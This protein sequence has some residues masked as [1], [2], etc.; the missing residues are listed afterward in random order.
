MA[1]A[2]LLVVFTDVI[3]YRIAGLYFPATF[4]SL[5]PVCR[6]RA[7][8][9]YSTRHSS[10]WLTVAFTLDRTVAICYQRLQ[11]VCCTEQTAAVIIAIV[12]L[13]LTL[14]NIPRCF[15]YEPSFTVN[16]VPWFCRT[17]PSYYTSPAWT[18][19]S[20]LQRILTPLLPFVLVLLLN[21]LTVRHIVRSSR[22]RRALR[23]GKLGERCGDDPE[24]ENRRRSIVVLFGIS[25]TFILLWSSYVM[26]F[27]YWRA[28]GSR[29]HSGPSDPLYIA[30][31]TGYM[32]LLLNCCTNTCVYAVTQA[33]FRAEIKTV[34]ALPWGRLRGL[35]KLRE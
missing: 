34:L 9:L 22:V 32:L 23:A 21:A 10:V 1:V 12:C 2:D 6:L 25:G 26:Y 18:A 16:R 19:F 33:R 24:L 30:R 5:T 11:V 29:S 15:K 3:L 28:T 14:Q 31:E 8:V 20:W 35:I 17:K 4:L 7:Y 13:F 27:L